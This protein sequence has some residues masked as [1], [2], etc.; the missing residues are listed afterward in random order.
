MAFQEE[1]GDEMDGFFDG[2][3]FVNLLFIGKFVFIR[4]RGILYRHH[5]FACIGHRIHHVPNLL[6]LHHSRGLR[7]VDRDHAHGFEF[8]LQGPNLVAKIYI[9]GPVKIFVHCQ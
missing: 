6:A 9:L 8:E 2:L 1:F 4:Q 5:D 3:D 7:H